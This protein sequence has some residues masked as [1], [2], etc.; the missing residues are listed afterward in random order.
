VADGVVHAIGILAA[1]I[2]GGLL[3]AF[4]LTTRGVPLATAGAIYALHDGDVGGFGGL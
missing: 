4:A 3:V 1:L 2:G